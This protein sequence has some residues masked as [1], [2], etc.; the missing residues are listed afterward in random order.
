MH[1]R[2][3]SS[4]ILK[5]RKSLVKNLP[6]TRIQLN[7]SRHEHGPEKEESVHTENICIFSLPFIVT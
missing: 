5:L 4:T 7:H 3:W 2:C 6:E 1:K